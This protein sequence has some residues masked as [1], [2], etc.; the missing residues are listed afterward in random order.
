MVDQSRSQT[1]ASN[2]AGILQRPNAA[3]TDGNVTNTS[4]FTTVNNGRSYTFDTVTSK[5]RE[6]ITTDTL[7]I[8]SG[9]WVFISPQSNGQL[10][11]IVP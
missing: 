5:F 2:K 11:H 9:I 4:Y 3:G 1:Q 6:Q 7:N 10:P 8:G